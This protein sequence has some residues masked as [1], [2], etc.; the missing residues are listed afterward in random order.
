[1]RPSLWKMPWLPPVH[2]GLGS[3][4]VGEFAMKS[5]PWPNFTLTRLRLSRGRSHHWQTNRGNAGKT[6]AAGKAVI[7]FDTYQDYDY[8]LIEDYD[9]TMKKFGEKR[10]TKD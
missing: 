9:V 2:L 10:E 5:M 1:M 3:V 6:A 4:V 8:S 7:H